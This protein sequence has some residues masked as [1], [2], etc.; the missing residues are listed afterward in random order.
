MLN[1]RA[2]I[3]ESYCEDYKSQNLSLN[4]AELINMVYSLRKTNYNIF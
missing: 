1:Q 4:S 2:F 3:N